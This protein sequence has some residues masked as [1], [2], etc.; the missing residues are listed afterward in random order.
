MPS[1]NDRL[2]KLAEYSDCTGC[3]ACADSCTTDSIIMSHDGRLFDY[4]VINADTCLKCGKCVTVC[5]A[6]NE[7]PVNT[8][9]QQ[10]YAAWNECM[11]DRLASTSGGV[12]TALGSWAIKQ[13]YKVCGV[14][15]SDEWKVKHSLAS[16][17]SEL[18]AFRGSK[19]VQSKTLG[20]YKTIKDTISNG[21]KVLFIG[22]PCQVEGIKRFL[23]ERLKGNLLTCEIICH[24]VNSPYVWNDFRTA[25]VSDVKSDLVS[26]SFRSKSH[27]WQR[28]KGGPNLRVA[29][30]FK[31]GK[32]VDAPAFKNQ[33]HYWFG[34]HLILR[35]SYLHCHFRQEQRRADITIADFWGV[36]HVI[37]GIDTKNGVSAVIV[38]SAKG[39]EFLESVK[40]LH[41]EPVDE[42]AT[43]KILRG[44]VET[45]SEEQINVEVQTNRQ[46]AQDYVSN[47]Y[48]SMAKRYPH[49][50][51]LSMFLYKVKSKLGL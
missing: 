40:A 11:R 46:F 48:R 34:Q 32:K 3:S 39:L 36:E 37:P 24:G 17:E 47:G 33:F 45:K 50:T 35:E 23:P 13:G 1:T 42:I 30:S 12:G 20:I 10:Y 7:L 51:D 22:T 18:E 21:H 15:F 43:K 26:Y 31:N 6:I 5:P 14:Q 19:Y 25:L 41:I 27:G 4:P 38:S 28:K 29:Y 9:R 44:F 16:T 2:I 49:H 8:Y